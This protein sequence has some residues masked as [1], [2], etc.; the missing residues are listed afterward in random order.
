[1]MAHKWLNLILR[2]SILQGSKCS[3]WHNQHVAH[4]VW[5]FYTC[6]VPIVYRSTQQLP[7]T[8]HNTKCHDFRTGDVDDI[9]N[10]I[11]GDTARLDAVLFGDIVEPLDDGID[12]V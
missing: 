4:Q 12:D 8:L 5:L 3:A 10:H 7:Q 1:M 9:G 11:E 6:N 2:K